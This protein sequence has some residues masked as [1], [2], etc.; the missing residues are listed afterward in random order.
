MHYNDV[1]AQSLLVKQQQQLIR[2]IVVRFTLAKLYL[3]I[4]LLFSKS[5]PFSQSESICMY[6]SSLVHHFTLSCLS[7]RILFA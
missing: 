6:I 1:M 3:L 2:F 7:G 5:G 4:L